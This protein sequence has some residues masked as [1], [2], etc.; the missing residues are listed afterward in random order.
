[1]CVRVGVQFFLQHLSRL[2]QFRGG[3]GAP[4]MSGIRPFLQGAEEEEEEEEAPHIGLPYTV[5]V[6][7][8]RVFLDSRLSRC[9][10]WKNS[11]KLNCL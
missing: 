7:S 11:W 5:T 3:I 9:Q 4:P 10:N 8:P 6:S 2:G 1:M